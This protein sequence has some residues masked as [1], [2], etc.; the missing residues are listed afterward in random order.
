[1]SK[2]V[3]LAALAAAAL[4]APAAAQSWGVGVGVTIGEPPVY[5]DPPP[6]YYEPAPVYVAPPVIGGPPPVYVAP[7]PVAPVLDMVSPDEV[8][9][10]LDQAGYTD[11]TPMARR[12]NSYRLN[13]VDPYGN[14]V[15]LLISIFSG[16][17]ERTDILQAAYA[18]PPPPATPGRIVEPVA[19]VPPRVPQAAPVAPPVALAPQ[20][21]P[22]PPPPPTDDDEERAAGDDPLVIY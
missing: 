1:M 7:G 17:I 6:V 4:S 15:A 5:Y 3:L 18:P 20:A 2:A 11:L 14:L 10:R 22:P 9:D 8:F 16:E 13:A 21:T 19:G 12:G